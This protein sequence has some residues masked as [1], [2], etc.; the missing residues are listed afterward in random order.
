MDGHDDYRREDYTGDALRWLA[1]GFGAGLLIGGIVGLLLAPKSGRE[2]REQIAGIATD[3]SKKTRDV[4]GEVTSRAT[5]TYGLVSDRARTT[6]AD[7]TQKVRG[8]TGTV[9]DT[10]ST[11]KDAATRALEAAKKG[12][13]KKVGELEGTGDYVEEGPGGEPTQP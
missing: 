3:L 13:R 8:V 12:Y 9:K 1:A 5:S 10:V 6:A 7:V 11:A 2:T 4:A